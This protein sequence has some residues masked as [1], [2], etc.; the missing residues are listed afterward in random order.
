MSSTYDFKKAKDLLKENN[1]KYKDFLPNQKSLGL[2][3]VIFGAIPTNMKGIASVLG[4]EGN[5][6]KGNK[7]LERFRLQIANSKFSYYNDEI[8]FLL[9][10]TNVDVIQSRN[11]YSYVTPL[12]NS[13]NDKSLLKTYLQGYTAFR[14]AMPMPQLN[15]LKPHPKAA[16]TP[17]CHL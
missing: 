8:V 12:L 15:L 6:T 17:T 10:F 5:I 9:C 1:E 7:Q 11:S 3:E 13:M 16:S 14:T 2:I 4:I